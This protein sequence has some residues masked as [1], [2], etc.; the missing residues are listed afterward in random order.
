[1]RNKGMGL[2]L[3][4]NHGVLQRRANAGEATYETHRIAEGV[5]KGGVDFAYGDTFVHEANLDLLHGVDFKKGCYVGQEVVARV[6]FRKSARKRIV[7]IRFAGK[8]P[9]HGTQIMAGDV[10]I[11][12]VGS[13]AGH[14]GLAMLRLDRLQDSQASGVP[15][16]AGMGP[17]T[18]VLPE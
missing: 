15:L 5:P 1:M 12:Q 11:G 14:E 4:Y 2:R 9:A 7:K 6:E 16:R 10:G 13:T 18:V 3:I 17:I 8:A